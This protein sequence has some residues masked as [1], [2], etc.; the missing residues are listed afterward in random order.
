MVDLEFTTSENMTG[1]K[2]EKKKEE[3]I[4]AAEYNKKTVKRGKSEDGSERI[5]N[6]QSTGEIACIWRIKGLHVT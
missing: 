1:K 4:T 3:E 5:G 2:E 6:I